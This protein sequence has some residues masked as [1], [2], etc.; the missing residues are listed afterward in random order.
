VRIDTLEHAPLATLFAH[1]A[2]P[3]AL[4]PENARLSPDYPGAARQRVEALRGGVALFLAGP[5]GDQN[6]VT[7]DPPPQGAYTLGARL[8]DRVAAIADAITPDPDAPLAF[9]TDAFELPPVD[10]RIRCAGILLGPIF[11]RSATR[12]LPDRARL[13]ALRL[14]PLRLL[15][16][17]F[18]LGVEVA[19][20][21]HERQ[22]APLAVVAHAG[23]WLGY[24]LMP[25]DYAQGG[26]EACLGFHGPGM[27]PR[28]VDEALSVLR[29]LE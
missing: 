16:S 2:H 4:P 3:V 7:S 26:Y 25:D 27:A 21:L 14:G 9:A 23:A 10:V 1:A 20:A 8:G 17:P 18:E 12:L 5:L 15:A 13:D 28:F 11:H 29:R 19:Q 6:P 24:L 22:E